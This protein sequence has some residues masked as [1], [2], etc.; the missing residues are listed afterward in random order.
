MRIYLAEKNNV[1]I[2]FSY[3][4]ISVNLPCLQRN[5]DKQNSEGKKWEYFSVAPRAVET[6]LKS[7]TVEIP[8]GDEKP[9][10]WNLFRVE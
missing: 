5:K 6:E 4:V 10:W 1:C 3:S 2:L 7:S 8:G 9:T